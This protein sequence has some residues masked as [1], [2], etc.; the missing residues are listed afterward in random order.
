M[1]L[2]LDQGKARVFMGLQAALQC[3]RSCRF[4]SLR[5]PTAKSTSLAASFSLKSQVNDGV[6]QLT[7]PQGYD[8][9]IYYQICGNTTYRRVQGTC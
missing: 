4:T 3:K 1:H 6:Y 8:W 5:A 9:T 7:T 2:S